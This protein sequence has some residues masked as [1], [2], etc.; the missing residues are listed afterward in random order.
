VTESTLGSQAGAAAP[1]QPAVPKAAR[2]AGAAEPTIV[3]TGWTSVL[4]AKVPTTATTPDTT[5]PD[6]SA[7]PTTGTAPGGPAARG[8]AADLNA[9]LGSLPAV[10]G[11]WGSGR[12]LQSALFSVLITDDGRI[13]AGA[14][15][16]DLLYT[17]AAQ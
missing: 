15:A 14:V 12:L 10:S 4:V 3:G 8:S 17:A 16:P 9:I 6:S 5:A 7:P 2:P 1:D 11:D 13:I